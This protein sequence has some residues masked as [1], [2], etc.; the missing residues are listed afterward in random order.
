MFLTTG[1]Q[2]I[3]STKFD[4]GIPVD[5]FYVVIET[6]G[7]PRAPTFLVRMLDETDSQIRFGIP[8]CTVIY[9]RTTGGRQF[10]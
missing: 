4:F 7:D 3:C 2:L 10:F 6:L 9:G 5:I 1:S 8:V